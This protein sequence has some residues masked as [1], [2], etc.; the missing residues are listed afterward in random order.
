M[1][2]DLP[3]YRTDGISQCMRPK[4][5]EKITIK[6]VTKIVTERQNSSWK[7]LGDFRDETSPICSSASRVRASKVET[8]PTGTQAL[9]FCHQ[10]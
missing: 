3:M 9:H 7:H 5:I 8:E 1:V 6:K 10:A 4:K 2:P